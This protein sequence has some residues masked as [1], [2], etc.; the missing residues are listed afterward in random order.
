M[1]QGE[2]E[3]PRIDPC[4][5][6][7]A[8]PR[9]RCAARHRHPLRA[10]AVAGR[11]TAAGVA[12]T[13]TGVDLGGLA[14]AGAGRAGAG[15]TDAGLRIGVHGSLPVGGVDVMSTRRMVAPGTPAGI[16]ESS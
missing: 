4:L 6:L 2:A 12:A 5:E 11:A 7:A 16:V 8:R 15:S 10:L 9:H 14:A 3:V 13:A 1:P